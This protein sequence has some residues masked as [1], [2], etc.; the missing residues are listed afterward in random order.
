MIGTAD[1]SLI[2]WLDSKYFTPTIWKEEGWHEIKIWQKF[3]NES[4]FP[5]VITSDYKSQKQEMN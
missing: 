3:R 1:T 2:D 4:I 5:I